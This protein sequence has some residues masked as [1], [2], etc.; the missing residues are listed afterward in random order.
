[1]SAA[2]REGRF[3]A[4]QAASG[5]GLQAYVI[6]A[7]REYRGGR[8]KQRRGCCRTSSTAA[9]A[10]DGTGVTLLYAA[11]REHKMATLAEA[12]QTPRQSEEIRS[13]AILAA[14]VRSRRNRCTSAEI[15]AITRRSVLVVH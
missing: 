11:I 6:L 1:M 9:D 10:T 3:R 7:A 15:E 12:K 2:A 8:H 4:G 5:S 13:Y 14:E